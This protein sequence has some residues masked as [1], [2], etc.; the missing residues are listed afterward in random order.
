MSD[1]QN[2]FNFYVEARV[3]ADDPVL[4]ANDVA[5]ARK[6]DPFTSHLSAKKIT[7]RLGT[8]DDAIHK[9]LLAVGESG[10][11]SDEIVEMTGIKYRSVT[12]RLKPM[13]RKGLVTGGRET[14]VGESGHKN[15]VWKA[16]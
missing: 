7:P 13:M 4:S 16:L 5:R 6:S 3:N 8:I 12:P 1:K 15:L 11:T 2:S 14:R 9:A 10:A